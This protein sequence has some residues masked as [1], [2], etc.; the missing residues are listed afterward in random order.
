MSDRSEKHR[1][2]QHLDEPFKLILWTMDELIVLFVPFLLLMMLFDSPISGL[3]MGIVAL[4][5]MKKIKGEQ[6][7]YF[8]YNLMYWYLPSVIHFKKTPPSHLRE[9][10]G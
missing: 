8:L 7:H 9:W 6:G 4:F 5:G 2:P 10:I 1:I 3:I